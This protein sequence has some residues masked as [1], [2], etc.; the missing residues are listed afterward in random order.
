MPEKEIWRAFNHIILGI[1]ILLN[2]FALIL[3]MKFEII[4]M[5]KY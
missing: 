5:K 1:I 2:N 4:F 3:F